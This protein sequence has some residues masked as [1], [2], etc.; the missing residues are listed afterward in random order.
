MK[1]IISFGLVMIIL[2]TML[3]AAFADTKQDKGE[4][5]T[6]ERVTQEA[7]PAIEEIAEWKATELNR[8]YSN[9]NYPADNENWIIEVALDGLKFNIKAKYKNLAEKLIEG[10]F[11]QIEGQQ[12]I[13]LDCYGQDYLNFTFE[14]TKEII[15]EAVPAVAEIKTLFY[16]G[17]E[18]ENGCKVLFN[19][20]LELTDK[21]ALDK[22][23][24]FKPNKNKVW[25]GRLWWKVY[26]YKICDWECPPV[27][28]T[29]TSTTTTDTTTTPSTTTTTT[30]EV[31]TTETIQPTPSTTTEETTTNTV[32]ESSKED[33]PKTGESSPF[34]YIVIGSIA[35]FVG[36]AFLFLR[37]R[38]N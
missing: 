32:V 4:Y 28:T 27:Q 35:L 8:T 30:T 16:I 36:G 10:T 11:E 13:R 23:K 26:L 17:Y 20:N 33:L 37:F 15:Q 29:T 25:S 7:I 34:L 18:Y 31:T 2:L 19:K 6:E 12:E 5:I 9:E 22:K 21:K 1:K 14:I 24:P 3:S 38:L